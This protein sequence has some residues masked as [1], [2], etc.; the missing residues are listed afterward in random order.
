MV[1]S[2]P[3]ELIGIKTKQFIPFPLLISKT[4]MEHFYQ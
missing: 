4:T 2:N 1:Y 3:I